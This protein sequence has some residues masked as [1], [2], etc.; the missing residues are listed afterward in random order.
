M[1]LGLPLTPP[2][3]C[4]GLLRLLAPTE[5]TVAAA[6]LTWLPVHVRAGGPSQCGRLV[7][8]RSGSAWL[9]RYSQDWSEGL[10]P[11]FPLCPLFPDTH[12]PVRV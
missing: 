7:L 12:G 2:C 10:R 11:W 6:Q 4:L 9:P 8:S 3:L 5:E 1:F